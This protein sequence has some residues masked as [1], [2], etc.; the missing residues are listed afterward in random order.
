M[1]IP[2]PVVAV[3][4]NSVI[5]G[6]TVTARN[7]SGEASVLGAGI[8]N[9][10]QLELRNVRVSDNVAVG[11]GTSGVVQGGGIRNATIFNAGPSL[12]TLV[13]ST[14]T[15]NKLVGAPGTTLQG[16]GLYT[17]FPITMRTTSIRN[18]TPD[19]CFGCLPATTHVAGSTV[20]PT[21]AKSTRHDSRERSRG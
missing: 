3:I 18:N 2:A 21:A 12:L 14:I 1:N 9:D 19:D 8:V 11:S 16:A 6:N 13:G 10:D 7:P 4:K 5:S 17:D 15:H 20:A